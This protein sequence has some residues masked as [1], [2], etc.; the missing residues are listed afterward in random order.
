MKK[1]ID[2]LFVQVKLYAPTCL[3]WTTYSHMFHRPGLSGSITL[4]GYN[5]KNKIIIFLN[6]S[7]HF[8][9]KFSVRL[10][11]SAWS[12]ILCATSANDPRL[13]RIFIPAFIHYFFCPILILE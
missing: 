11:G 12:F 13:Q 7:K 1:I 2:F 4:Y 8:F 9:F 10:V 5:L 3:Y 6:N